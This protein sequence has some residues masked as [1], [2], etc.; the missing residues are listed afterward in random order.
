MKTC[1]PLLVDAFM[2]WSV[3]VLSLAGGGLA[4]REA[5]RVTN[6]FRLRGQWRAAPCNARAVMT[7]AKVVRQ[8]EHLER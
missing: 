1:T 6:D 4:S 5:P 7:L 3:C 2:P 8:E